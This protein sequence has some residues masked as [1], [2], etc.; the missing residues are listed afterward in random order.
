MFCCQG[1]FLSSSLSISECD[2]VIDITHRQDNANPTSK[3]RKA[4]KMSSLPLGELPSLMGTNTLTVISFSLDTP[5]SSSG[6]N[7]AVDPPLVPPFLSLHNLLLN[8]FILLE[9]VL[10]SHF[11]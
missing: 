8:L 3:I 2:E 4:S 9:M 11:L 5:Q 6:I 10:W 1:S 7:P